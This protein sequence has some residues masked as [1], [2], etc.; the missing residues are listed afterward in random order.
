M[1]CE[2][3]RVRSAEAME[4]EEQ[5]KAQRI[6]QRWEKE[7]K[8]HIASTHTQEEREETWQTEETE[9]MHTQTEMR[10]DT[11]NATQIGKEEDGGNNE[12][13]RIGGKKKANKLTKE[14]KEKKKKSTEKIKN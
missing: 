14:I 6:E 5:G 9:Q 11:N 2:K 8:R 3:G 4:D 12:K 13:R 1:E 7:I 10:R